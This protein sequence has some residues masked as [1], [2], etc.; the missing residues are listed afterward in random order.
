M[1]APHIRSVNKGCHAIAVVVHEG[2][3]LGPDNAS[4]AKSSDSSTLDLLAATF[5]ENERE[6]PKQYT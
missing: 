6:D 3:I 1:P 5:Q 2:R 4:L